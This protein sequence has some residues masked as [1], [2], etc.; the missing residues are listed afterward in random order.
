LRIEVSAVDAKCRFAELLRIVKDGRSVVVTSHGK[1]VA[2]ISP[3]LED[4]RVAE[5]AL[6]AL[7]AWLRRGLAANAVRSTREELYDD[8]R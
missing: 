7:F 4:S 8:V 3:V 1:Q 6:S 5:S 2:K